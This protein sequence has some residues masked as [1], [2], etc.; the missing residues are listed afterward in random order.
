MAA[1]QR[2]IEGRLDQPV[3]TVDS[4]APT[5]PIPEDAEVFVSKATKEKAQKRKENREKSKAKAAKMA[6]ALKGT[7]KGMVSAHKLK[8]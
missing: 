8:S 4:G 6:G 7:L 5:A 3:A 1:I 2:A